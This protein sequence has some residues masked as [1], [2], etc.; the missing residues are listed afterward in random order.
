MC[1]V[2]RETARSTFLFRQASTMPKCSRAAT[3]RWNL[4]LTDSGRDLFTRTH[5][6]SSSLLLAP[7]GSPTIRR[8]AARTHDPRD[9]A[10]FRHHDFQQLVSWLPTESALVEGAALSSDFRSMKRNS[11]ARQLGGRV[12]F[13]QC[14]GAW[15]DKPGAAAPIQPPLL[16]VPQ[17]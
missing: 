10:P 14:G 5:H 2:R 7:P 17:D 3:S 16:A 8:C 12:I 11:R 6:A 4:C 9:I 13:T 1:F 15:R